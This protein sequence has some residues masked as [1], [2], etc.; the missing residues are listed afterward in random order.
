MRCGCA[1]LTNLVSN[2]VKFTLKGEVVVEARALPAQGDS[3]ARVEIRVRDT[4]VGIS[5]AAQRIVFD[6]FEQADR[7]TTRRFGG[8]GLG[9]SICRRLLALMGGGIAVASRVGE[10]SEF[11]LWFPL[12]PAAE[13]APGSGAPNA[14]LEGA[15]ALVVDDNETNRLIV[16]HYLKGLGLQVTLCGDSREVPG[17]IAR[18]AEGGQPFDLLLTDLHMP[19]VDGLSPPARSAAMHAAPTCRSRC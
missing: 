12:E 2:A 5:E 11:R 8:T 10:G 15:R 9:L 1:V 16:E 18:A 6:A 3:E 4:G 7:S 17:L 13:D 19:H 14:M